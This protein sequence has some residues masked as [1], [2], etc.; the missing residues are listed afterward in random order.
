[1]ETIMNIDELPVAL[2]ADD[3]GTIQRKLTEIP[4]DT[5]GIGGMTVFLPLVGQMLVLVTLN[6][7]IASWCLM[8]ARERDRARALAA[9]MID[10]HKREL[11]IAWNDVKSIADNAIAR[12]S[13]AGHIEAPRT[14]R[15]RST[16]SYP[17]EWDCGAP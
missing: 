11:E 1:M 4:E 3:Q 16:D 15:R 7:E 14:A 17:G 2:S 13:S 6:G 12:A 8:P 10:L 9:Q 5:D